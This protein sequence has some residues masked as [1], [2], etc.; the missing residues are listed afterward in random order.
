MRIGRRAGWR[1][2]PRPRR[3]R[4]HGM[5][6]PSPPRL[7]PARP[8][9]PSCPASRW[10]PRRRRYT[11]SPIRAILAARRRWIRWELL[12][13]RLIRPGAAR[14][15]RAHAAGAQREAGRAPRARRPREGA[16]A[17]YQIFLI[18]HAQSA[19]T[20]KVHARLA[21]TQ[22]V[23]LEPRARAGNRRPRWRRRR[24]SSAPL[25][26]PP[27]RLGPSAGQ[28][29]PRSRSATLWWRAARTGGVV[30]GCSAGSRARRTSR[31]PS[32]PSAASA[33]RCTPRP[34]QRG[35]DRPRGLDAAPSPTARRLRQRA[36]SPRRRRPPRGR[37]CCRAR[38]RAGQEQRLWRRRRRRAAQRPPRVRGAR[39]R[40]GR[41]RPTVA[42]PRS[43][44][45]ALRVGAK[46][47]STAT[48]AASGAPPARP[49]RRRS[50]SRPRSCRRPPRRRRPAASRR[51]RS[52]RRRRPTADPPPRGRRA[53][54]GRLGR[55]R[56]ESAS[57]RS[58]RRPRRGCRRPTAANDHG[59][60]R[61]RPASRAGPPPRRRVGARVLE[62]F[63]TV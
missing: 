14:R 59:D 28:T 42:A 1:L 12:A 20:A 29:F 47:R 31:P 17:C 39:R 40:G 51:H 61:R 6:P 45:R 49:P 22:R 43:R 13:E 52:R 32:S 36:C 2:S 35:G 15:R 21:A 56:D 54:V 19:R 34:R 37:R 11:S 41:C 62:C 16:S 50:R 27:P 63:T 25:A 44:S 3:C 9:S 26:P 57:T 24:Q 18:S 30:R 38:R 58:R 48:R 55:P 7:S 60:R 33:R 46:L 23:D 10:P 8:S 53:A 5:A 4:L